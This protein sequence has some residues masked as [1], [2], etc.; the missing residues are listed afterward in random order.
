MSQSLPLKVITISADPEQPPPKPAQPDSTPIYVPNGTAGYAETRARALG[1]DFTGQ[2][3]LY[4]DL[5]GPDWRDLPS[6]PGLGSD[7]E[8]FEAARAIAVD[9]DFGPL[10]FSLNGLVESCPWLRVWAVREYGRVGREWFDRW[11]EHLGV[12][13][14]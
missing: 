10:A 4:A 1:L 14:L 2:A 9:G 12:R 3:G 13:V 6:G 8:E 5:Y 11:W 7:A